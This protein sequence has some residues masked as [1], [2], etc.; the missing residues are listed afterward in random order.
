MIDDFFNRIDHGLAV[1]A[2]KGVGVEPPAA[3]AAKPVSKRAPEVGVT[4]QAKRTV[5]TLK[6]GI[7]AADGVDGAALTALRA[8]LK[9]E[10]V[11]SVLISQFL[12][13]IRGADGTEVEVDKPFF[14]TASVEY[15][16]ILVPGGAASA[17]ALGTQGAALHFLEET[18]KHGKTIGAT[19]EG[20]DLLAMAR[21][22]GVTLAADD[23]VRESLGVR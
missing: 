13:T 9:Q 14:A 3:G 19:G 2:A 18:F 7:L 4:H 8:R 17:A 11:S 21:L 6:V 22:D 1:R 15:D 16:A 12:G 23:A 10:G 20:V 5:R